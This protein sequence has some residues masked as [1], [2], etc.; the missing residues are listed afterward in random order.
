MGL[1]EFLQ[2]S[3]WLP[4]PRSCTACTS[5]VGTDGVLLK[6]SFAGPQP[7]Q[8]MHS[9][10]HNDHIGMQLSCFLDRLAAVFCFATHLPVWTRR[11][12]RPK[13]L[14][15][16]FALFRNQNPSHR[17]P[18]SCLGQPSTSAISDKSSNHPTPSLSI[19]LYITADGLGSRGVPYGTYI[20]AIR[21]PLALTPFPNPAS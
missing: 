12:Q 17:S 10:I 21:G 3:L 9:E 16:R 14:A 15:H 13:R 19:S 18:Q 1:A 2:L 5:R 4:T 7:V 11:K 8:V 6:I 20:S